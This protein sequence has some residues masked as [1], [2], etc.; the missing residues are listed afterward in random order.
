M[1]P[2]VASPHRRTLKAS[3]TTP[4]ARRQPP[5][6]TAQPDAWRD[7][8]RT[9]SNWVSING[10]DVRRLIDTAT[11]A[12]REGLTVSIRRGRSQY[13][14]DEQEQADHLTDM[15]EVFTEQ[16]F[17]GASPYTF[18]SPVAPHRPQRPPP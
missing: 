18:I 9:A 17:L 1:T 16:G 13:V 6:L 12:L 15:L 3:R 5:A 7:P 14:R 11:A 8:C 2:A 10:S 4:A